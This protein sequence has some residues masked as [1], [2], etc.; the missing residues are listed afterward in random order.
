VFA[1]NWRRDNDKER[2]SKR[3]LLFGILSEVPYILLTNQLNL[4][5][6]FSFLGITQTFGYL[7]KL[8]PKILILI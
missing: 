4:N 7:K 2:L 5:V 8:E 6:M 1:Q 3:L